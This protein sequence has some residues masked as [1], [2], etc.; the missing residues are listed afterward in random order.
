MGASQWAYAV[1]FQ[2]DINAALQDL[3]QKVFRS[4]NYYTRATFNERLLKEVPNLP[5][6]VRLRTQLSLWRLRR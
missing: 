3:R 4:G 5:V 1:P 2:P 6:G